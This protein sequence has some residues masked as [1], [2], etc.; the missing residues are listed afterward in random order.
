MEDF[1][2][3]VDLQIAFSQQAL[4]S[5]IFFFEFTNTGRFVS[6]QAAKASAPAVERVFCDVVLTADFSDGFFAFFSLLQD[7]DD[8]LVGD[9]MVTICSSVN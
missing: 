9:K 7:G 8:L 6:I 1:L 5:G 2:D 3:D 4:Q